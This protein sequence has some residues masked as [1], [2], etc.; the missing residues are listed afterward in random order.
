M[1]F[2]LSI[3]ISCF[4]LLTQAF[5]QEVT[6]NI[7]GHVT[8]PT[9]SPVVNAMVSVRNI[10]QNIALRNLNTNQAGDYAATYLAGW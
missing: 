1:R 10:D 8:D 7:L 4:I 3:A 9:G 2:T 5:A 6:G